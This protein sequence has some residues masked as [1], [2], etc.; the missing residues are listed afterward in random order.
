MAEGTTHAQRLHATLSTLSDDDPRID[1]EFFRIVDHDDIGHGDR[2]PPVVLVGVVHDHPASVHRVSQIVSTL[3]PEIV[4]LELPRIAMPLFETYARV[5][6]DH[7]NAGGEMSAAIRAAGD[8]RVVGLDMPDLGSLL[9]LARTMWREN[10][11]SHTARSIADDVWRVSRHALAGRLVAAGLPLAMVGGDVGRRQRYDVTDADPPAVQAEHERRHVRRS[12]SLL[13][14]LDMPS[15]TRLVDDVRERSIG[16][17][18][19][20]LQADASSPV[21]AVVG[22]DHLDRVVKSM[23]RVDA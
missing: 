22:Y 6:D 11:S 15:S 10:V 20:D 9:S 19:V 8:A 23:E 21:V 7:E 16:A 3:D 12:R 4:G 17:R 13:E 1:E 18:L 5:E 2:E 14:A